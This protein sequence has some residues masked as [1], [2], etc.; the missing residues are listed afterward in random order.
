M[1]GVSLRY[2]I[3]AIA[4]VP[5]WVRVQRLNC[6]IFILKKCPEESKPNDRFLCQKIKV[7]M[8]TNNVILHHFRQEQ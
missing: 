2:W 5:V 6:S 7:E 8:F 4:F 3:M 1:R